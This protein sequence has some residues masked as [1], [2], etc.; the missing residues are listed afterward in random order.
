MV[1]Y[2]SLVKEEVE[3]S[4]SSGQ[5]WWAVFEFW[6]S[7]SMAVSYLPLHII[8]G[9]LLRDRV[10]EKDL[11]LPHWCLS[12]ASVLLAQ[13]TAKSGSRVRAEGQR[14]AL[15]VL[16]HDS[17]LVPWGRVSSWTQVCI[18]ESQ[19]LPWFCL[20]QSLGSK[21]WWGVPDLLSGCWDYQS[22]WFCIMLL[23][24]KPYPQDKHLIILSVLS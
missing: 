20:S 10:P 24:T 16:F 12:W 22:S 19:Q 13:A 5:W 2:L 4:T 17:P 1:T 21:Y 23:A 15:G 7:G 11:F 18:S 14:K 6:H 3:P 9:P 8:L